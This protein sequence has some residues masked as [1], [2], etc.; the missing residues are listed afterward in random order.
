ME[1]MMRGLV[2]FV[3]EGTYLFEPW[4]CLDNGKSSDTHTMMMAPTRSVA[5]QCIYTEMWDPRSWSCRRFA[6]Y[7]GELSK[8]YKSQLAKVIRVWEQGCL[9]P[10]GCLTSRSLARH[11]SCSVEYDATSVLRHAVDVVSSQN[12][13][14]FGRFFGLIAVILSFCAYL[15]YIYMYPLLS[16]VSF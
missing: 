7:N 14:N 13:A 16:P 1:K 12:L 10:Y 4:S 5:H 15:V 2:F 9:L 3:S 6:V 11:M 8:Q